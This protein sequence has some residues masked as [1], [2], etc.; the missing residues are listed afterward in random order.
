MR[1]NGKISINLIG[2]CAV[3]KEVCGWFLISN[4]FIYFFQSSFPGNERQARQFRDPIIKSLTNGGRQQTIFFPGHG[5]ANQQF[6]NLDSFPIQQQQHTQQQQQ[7]NQIVQAPKI[8]PGIVQQKATINNDEK[9]L[10]SIQREPELTDAELREQA[11]SAHYSFESTIDDTINDHA[12]TR[13]ETRDGLS[14][15]G[16]YSY[17]D[18]FFRRTVHYAADENGYRVLK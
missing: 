5:N 12:I 10:R 3:H 2:S 16:M 17:S 8:F 4:P 14:L 18:G 1:I 7:K 11:E 15:N 9:S 6:E 13:Q